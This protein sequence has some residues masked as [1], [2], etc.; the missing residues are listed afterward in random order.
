MY[1]FHAASLVEGST[2]RSSPQGPQRNSSPQ[3]GASPSTAEAWSP[4]NDEDPLPE[5]WEERQDANGRTFY[6]D[7]IN[8]RTQW[9]Q[10]TRSAS[11]GAGQRRAQ[12]EADRRRMMAQTLARRNPGMTGAEVSYCIYYSVEA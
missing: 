4:D 1:T 9:D 8:R 12:M 7:H 3:S 11:V 6:V 10:P 2:G 5:G